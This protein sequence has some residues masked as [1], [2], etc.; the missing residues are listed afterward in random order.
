M[1][2]A[3]P[4]VSLTA[5]VDPDPDALQAAGVTPG[6]ASLDEALASVECEAVLV[7]SPPGTHHAVAKA[8][9]EAG[10]HVLC[11]K[12]L[13]TSLVDAL[14]LVEAS[15]RANRFVLVSQNY[16]YNAP[17]RA[18]QRAISE[19]E[20][21]DLIS[22]E[23]DFRRDTHKLFAA[24]DFRYSMRH[25]L[26][27]DM[28]IHH[29]DLLRAATGRDVR[30]VHARGW[31]APDSPF[32]HHPEVSAVLDLDDGV[33]VVYRATWTA[34]GPET[35]W[36]GDWELVGEEGRLLWTGDLEDRNVAEITVE[37]WD[38]PVRVLDQPALQFTERAATLRALRV[39]VE[40][41]EEPE[42]S[43]SDNVNSLAV[44][45]G[46]A[47]SIESGETVD[48]PRLMEAARDGKV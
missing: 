38:E 27:L 19:R 14:D 32:A 17:F 46:C 44:V 25:P 5:V 23:I 22:V 3:A 26:V 41:D 28:A 29:F 6:Y 16:R 24:D 10:K 45:L 11:E 8:A 4:N 39:A 20:I 7:S 48:I 36:N 21:G 1:I 13:A 12:P 31:R 35:S 47:R 2:Q 15:R 18:V 37:Q 42:T 33:P 9:L 40:T 30:R 43:A 34:R